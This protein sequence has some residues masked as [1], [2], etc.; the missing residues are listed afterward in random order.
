MEHIEGVLRRIAEDRECVNWDWSKRCEP[1]VGTWTPTDHVCFLH[2]SEDVKQDHYI[3]IARS[4]AFGLQNDADGLFEAELKED[5][6]RR[7][8]REL[9]EYEVA[10]TEGRKVRKPRFQSNIKWVQDSIPVSCLHDAY[11]R[12]T[13]N[14]MYEDSFDAY[15]CVSTSWARNSRT[16]ET[17]STINCVWLD[18][19]LKDNPLCRYSEELAYLFLE[20]LELT[21]ML[22][23]ASEAAI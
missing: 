22:V 3:T 8:E 2:G 18:L 17:L 21:G 1:F 16:T 12:S 5:N 9:K 13:F 10:Q 6:Q 11:E 20:C 7:Y 19:D 14:L 4:N 23:A 15:V